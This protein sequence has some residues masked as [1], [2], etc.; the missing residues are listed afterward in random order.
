MHG[1]SQWGEILCGSQLECRAIGKLSQ[2]LHDPFPE[3]LLPDQNTH[4]VIADGA[5]DNFSCACSSP[6]DQNRKWQVGH[7][8]SRR[9]VL[10]RATDPSFASEDESAVDESTCNAD[11]S[12]CE[13]PSVVPHVEDQ[14]VEAIEV[15]PQ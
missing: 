15:K 10:L 7:K 14:S 2:D 5:G 3:R 4:V 6:V 12:L 13:P 11:C 9:P 1:V 8:V